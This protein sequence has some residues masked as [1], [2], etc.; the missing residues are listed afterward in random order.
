MA[1]T[2]LMGESKPRPLGGVFYILPQY[3]LHIR[4]CYFSALLPGK[5]VII[6]LFSKSVLSGNNFLIDFV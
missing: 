4:R 3:L 6:L 5:L 1:N 2:P